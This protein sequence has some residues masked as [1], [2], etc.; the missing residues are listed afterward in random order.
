MKNTTVLNC[1]V[2]CKTQLY[3]RN[4]N[5]YVGGDNGENNVLE[6]KKYGTYM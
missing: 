5:M 4:I 2:D 3:F 6:M 1:C